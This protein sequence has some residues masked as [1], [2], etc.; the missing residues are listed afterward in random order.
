[1]MAIAKYEFS[2]KEELAKDIIET[3]IDYCGKE[4]ID[5]TG[6]VKGWEELED[7]LGFDSLDKVELTIHM[8]HRYDILIQDSNLTNIVTVND[9]INEVTKCV[10]E[11]HGLWV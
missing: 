4:D 8:E 11:K 6:K 9:L 2:T 5:V 10:S 1:M 3:I 7:D